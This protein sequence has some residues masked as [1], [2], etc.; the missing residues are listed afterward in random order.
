MSAA[1]L[2]DD[3]GPLPP[4]AV[5]GV[6][7]ALVAGTLPSPRHEI[8]HNIYGDQ[9]GALR[10]GDIKLVRGN[11]NARHPYNG[12]NGWNGSATSFSS[13]ASPCTPTP[14]LFNISA[15]ASEQHDL[16]SAQPALLAQLLARYDELGR[17]EVSVIDSGLCP[18]NLPQIDGCAANAAGQ[19][20]EPW[21]PTKLT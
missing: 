13:D 8:V 18:A 19:S 21:L 2:R 14:C 12:Y 1:T 5:P 16:A 15:D 4:D 6:W 10:V 20:W 17:S 3:S 9:P 11:P 7:E